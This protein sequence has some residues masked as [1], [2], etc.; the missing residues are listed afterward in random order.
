MGSVRDATRVSILGFSLGG[1]LAVSLGDQA[2]AIVEYYAGIS[3]LA[4]PPAKLAPTLILHGEA[5]E[6]VPVR[7]ARRLAALLEERHIPHRMHLHPG[8][9]HVFD[10][11]R[12]P[13]PDR[14]HGDKLERE[15]G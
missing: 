3:Q 15:H 13:G 5:D 2:D 10:R 11:D 12:S 8:A 9:D 6:I 4:A 7:E 1:F 14:I